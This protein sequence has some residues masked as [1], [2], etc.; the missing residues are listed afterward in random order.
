MRSDMMDG[1]RTPEHLKLTGNVDSNWRAVQQQFRLYLEA[2]GLDTKSD[3]RKVALLLTIAGPQAVEV[4]NTFIFDEEGDDTKLAKV[5]SK[6]EAHC[7]PKKNETYERCVFRSRL[8]QQGES[9]DSFLTDLKIKSQ[10]CSFGTLRASMIRDQIVFG[11][12]DKK[13][14]ERLL[15]DAELTLEGA[16]KICHASELCQKQVKTFREAGAVNVNVKESV[17]VDA[18]SRPENARH[19][20]RNK[21]KTDTFTCKRCGTQHK[22]RQCP[23]FVNCE[24]KP[25]E[26]IN[27]VNEDK[28]IAPLQINGTTVTLKLDTGAKAN[29]IS[30]SDITAMKERPKTQ[31]NTPVLKDYNGQSIECLGTCK[32]KVTVKDKVHKLLFSVVPEGLDSLLGDKACEDL[33]LVKRVYRINTDVTASPDSVD[34]I[35]QN[36][37]DVF[38]GFGVLPFTYKIQLKEN[39]QPVVHAARRVPVALRDGLKKELERMT[40]LG[41]IRKI[42]EPTDWVNSMVCVKKK[43]GELRICMDPKDLNE[44]IKREHYQ[45]PKREEI[46]SEMA[47]AKNPGRRMVEKLG[48]IFWDGPPRSRRPEA[49][50]RRSSGMN[51]AGH[52]AHTSRTLRA[53]PLPF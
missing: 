52:F 30:M 36:Y 37:S 39:A 9:F 1:L 24:N 42:E 43:N 5:L 19:G 12:D 33:K 47:G 45:T 31:G 27:S 32:L 11:I 16:I 8:Q 2:V 29:L 15:R 40:T 26:E 49:P 23:A 25:E 10:S 38:R 14:R 44:N 7:S 34:S 35:V 20:V 18:I 21:Q 51:S 6:F 41:V 50:G 13:V 46:T 48:P 4:Y 28:W 17:D 3:A 22:P 53:A